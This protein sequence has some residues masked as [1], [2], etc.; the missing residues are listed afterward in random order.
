MP[1]ISENT[2]GHP[3]TSLLFAVVLLVLSA[4][5]FFIKDLRVLGGAFLV[6]LLAQATHIQKKNLFITPPFVMAVYL[7][8]SRL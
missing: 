1:E 8:I 5:L 6:A 7:Y 2:E 4:S 3:A